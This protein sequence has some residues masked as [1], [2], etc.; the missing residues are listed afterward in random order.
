VVNIITIPIALTMEKFVSVL[1][2]SYL[3]E[4]IRSYKTQTGNTG[5]RPQLA[6]TW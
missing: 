1:P 2:P 6:E 3:A 5:T 4:T